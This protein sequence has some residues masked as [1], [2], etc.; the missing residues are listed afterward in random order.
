MARSGYEDFVNLSYR[1]KDDELLALYYLEPA[2]GESMKRAAGAVA[3]E[4]SVGTWTPVPG[5]KLSHVG[6][7]AATVYEI[8]GNWVKIAYPLNNFE[9]GSLPQIFSSIAGNVFGMKA[10]ANL[11]LEDVRWPKAMM[12]SFPGPQFGIQGVRKLLKIYDRPLLACVPKPKVGMTS[13]EHVEIGYKIWTGGMDLLKDD[14]NL[15]SQPFNKFEKR[16]R[17]AMKMRGK[18][19]RETGERKSCLLNIT[20][21]WQEM[22]RRAKLVAREGNEYVMVDILTAG[23]SAVQGVR[24]LCQDL[25]LALYAHRAFHAAFTRNPKHG[26]SMLMVAEAARL[27]GVD[28]I[29]AGSAG[30][31]K[32]VG[33][34]GEAQL[35]HEHIEHSKYEVEEVHARMRGGRAKAGVRYFGEDWL[36]IKPVFP[37]TSGG[38]HP[39]ILPD[40]IRAFGTDVTIQVGG[41]TH[42]HPKGSHAGAK[43]VRQAV[44]ATMQGV[45]LQDYAETHREL[46]EALDYWGYLHPK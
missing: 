31:G 6:K 10:V 4:S 15:T 27:A 19:E 25:G 7:V 16:V 8:K 46:K 1:P 39:G 45:S 33:A 18:A 30:V 36:H 12:R 26:M 2:R 29:H 14:E 5:L 20:A 41:G 32:L 13:E 42:G 23:W 34:K 40:V 43:A 28:H 22:E 38:L 9:L 44:D 11:R 21:P 17:L 37:V 35:I 3:S 24:E